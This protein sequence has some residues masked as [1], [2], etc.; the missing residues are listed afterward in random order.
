MLGLS[1]NASLQALEDRLK[2]HG[3]SQALAEDIKSIRKNRLSG[4]EQRRFLK[5]PLTRLHPLTSTQLQT[6]CPGNAGRSRRARPPH[7]ALLRRMGVYIVFRKHQRPISANRAIIRYRQLVQGAEWQP[8]KILIAT[9]KGC[10]LSRTIPEP[11]PGPRSD[12][13]GRVS[14]FQLVQI[15]IHAGDDDE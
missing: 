10:S 7:I 9:S 2:A 6:V 8:P 13:I 5:L 11:D 12:L 14:P 3:F 4:D 1:A 15:P